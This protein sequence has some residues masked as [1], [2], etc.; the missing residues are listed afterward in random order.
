M[1]QHITSRASCKH[2]HYP[3]KTCV[4]AAIIPMKCAVQVTILQD[5]SESQHA[6]NTARLIPLILP[7]C[8]II[9]GNTPED[10]AALCTR[11]HPE[12]AQGHCAVI[13]PSPSALCV[14]NLATTNNTSSRPPF[15]HLI[16]L[17]GSWRKAKKIW[18]SNPWLHTLPV[19]SFAQVPDGQY[20]I[21]HTQLT[22]SLST[23]EALAH[24]LQIGF[25]VD[26]MPLHHIFSAMQA[27]W[28]KRPQ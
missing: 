19:L 9:V 17:D 14:E 18:L 2:C 5:P 11:L 22:D 3:Q 12:I 23:L 6:K 21:R 15:S 25:G 13:Y 24:T 4:C 16:L 8:D 20:H 10:F 27:H 7:N 28:P 26:T 1:T